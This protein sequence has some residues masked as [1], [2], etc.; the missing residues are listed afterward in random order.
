MIDIQ[1]VYA[2]EI[3]RRWKREADK[4][5]A[6]A[7]VGFYDSPA[8][9]KVRYSALERSKGRCE[10]C[11]NRPTSIN[12]LHV[13]H[14][15]PRSKY[16]KLELAPTNLEVLCRACNLGKGNRYETDWRKL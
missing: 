7:A 1:S 13:D 11:G 6:A 12:P 3:R 8:W 4:K 10:C 9:M 16:P 14:I 5:R 15:K 2:D